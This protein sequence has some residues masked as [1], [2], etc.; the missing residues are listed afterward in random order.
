MTCSDIRNDL[1]VTGSAD[2]GLRVYSSVN[3]VFKREL[4]D[5]KYGHTDWVTDCKILNDNRVVSSGM[6]S[7]ICLW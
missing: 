6:D 2:H 1:I 7:K 5:K 3:G 4:F